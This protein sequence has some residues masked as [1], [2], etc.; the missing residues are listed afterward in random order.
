MALRKYSWTVEVTNCPMTVGRLFPIIGPATLKAFLIL[1]LLCENSSK[2]CQVWTKNIV[3]ECNVTV[4]GKSI[5]WLLFWYNSPKQSSVSLT[6]KCLSS[7]VM[8]DNLFYEKYFK[9]SWKLLNLFLFLSNLYQISDAPAVKPTRGPATSTPTKRSASL[10]SLP[11][12]VVSPVSS[13]TSRTEPFPTSREPG[14]SRSVSLTQ[15]GWAGSREYESNEENFWAASPMMFAL[16]GPKVAA[17][18]LAPSFTA[19]KVRYVKKVLNK[20]Q[21]YGKLFRIPTQT[22]KAWRP[23]QSVGYEHR[24]I[25]KN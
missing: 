24:V 2:S 5:W 16:T 18:L 9:K 10:S 23:L 11:P 7:L 8:L 12:A 13:P 15:E 19:M 6:L 17:Q 14:Y 20:S 4:K 22:H 21:K 1:C 25:Y 3:E